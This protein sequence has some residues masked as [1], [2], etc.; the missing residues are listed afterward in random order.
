MAAFERFMAILP[1]AL[2]LGLLFYLPNYWMY[3]QGKDFAP[4][5]WWGVVTIAVFITAIIGVARLIRREAW[6]VDTKR[7]SLV[8]EIQYVFQD[9]RQY[10]FDLEDIEVVSARLQPSPFASTLSIRF[11]PDEQHTL[12]ETRTAGKQL[13][14]LVEQLDPSVRRAL[15]RPIEIERASD[16]E[17]E[18]ND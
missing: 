4:F 6:V 17:K 5:F 10:E 15:D 2:V 12:I 16:N 11:G 3:Y 14:T 8:Y 18:K 9:L 1:V 13:E 7:G